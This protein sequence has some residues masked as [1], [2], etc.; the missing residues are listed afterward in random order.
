MP[1]FRSVLSLFCRCLSVHGGFRFCITDVLLLK[2][3]LCC[4]V[5]LCGLQIY[6]MWIIGM[7]SVAKWC[8]VAC[9]YTWCE[10]LLSG[11][12]P[13]STCLLICC[14][15]CFG[16]LALTNHI[17]LLFSWCSRMSSWC[18][19]IL[20]AGFKYFGKVFKLVKCRM[21]IQPAVIYIYSSI[22]L[23]LIF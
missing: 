8:Y 16:C 10:I 12:I 7:S 6:L 18:L 15:F 13:L 21:N 11:L 20:N 5:V 1:N 22:N 4:W 19:C 17:K 9:S 23:H 14:F 2:T 3:D